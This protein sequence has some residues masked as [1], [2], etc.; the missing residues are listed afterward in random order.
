MAAEDPEGVDLAS[1]VRELDDRLVPSGIEWRMELRFDLAD[2]PI[3]LNGD[4]ASVARSPSIH[5]A[6]PS[7]SG[8]LKREGSSRRSDAAVSRWRS[9][10]PLPSPGRACRITS[11]STLA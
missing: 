1:D 3:L 4:E 6:M 11:P 5:S 8:S 9:A 10:R 7:A 2:D